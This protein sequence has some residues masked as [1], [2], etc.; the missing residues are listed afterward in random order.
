MIS[1]LLVPAGRI[2]LSNRDL[3]TLR[4]HTCHIRESFLRTAGRCLTRTCVSSPIASHPNYV[5]RQGAICTEL[6]DR[7]AGKPACQ[8][9]FACFSPPA[10]VVF[11]PGSSRDVSLVDPVWLLSFANRLFNTTLQISSLFVKLCIFHPNSAREQWTFRH[12]FSMM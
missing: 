5:N 2:R 7:S 11:S 8:P 9:K 6:R 10:P 12:C 3:D 1:P 4:L